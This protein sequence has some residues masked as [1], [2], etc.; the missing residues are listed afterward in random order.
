ML[1]QLLGFR[2]SKLRIAKVVEPQRPI[3][4]AGK[5]RIRE[6]IPFLIRPF[7]FPG[8]TS[9]ATLSPASITARTMAAWCANGTSP[10]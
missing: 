10:A 6:E 9:C 1:A 7:Y 3:E 5:G 2:A 8:A 4:K